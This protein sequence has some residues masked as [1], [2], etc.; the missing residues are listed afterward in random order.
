MPQRLADA[1]PLEPADLS[2]FYHQ[3][4]SQIQ[5]ALQQCSSV[6]K[7]EE[8]F[9]TWATAIENS[10][11]LAIQTEHRADPLQQPTPCLPRACRGRCQYR[12][13]KPRPLSRSAPHGRHGDYQA[14]TEAITVKARAKVRQ[15]RRLTTLAQGLRKLS[16]QTGPGGFDLHGQLRKEW[17]AIKRAQG[18]P[19]QFPEWL[20]RTQHF[21]EDL[22][23]Q[24][25]LN[26]VLQFVR[27]DA[28][29]TVRHEAKYRAKV[30]KFRVHQDQ[31]TGHSRLGFSGLRP[32]ARPPF[33]HVPVQENQSA[34][35]VKAC[36][37][38]VG[39]YRV[40][41]PE[42]VKQD[43]AILIDRQAAELLEHVES[44]IDGHLLRIK[45]QTSPLP[46][47]AT[48]QQY[49]CAST[50]RELHRAFI[51]FWSPIWHR[52]KGP[53]RD[54]EAYWDAFLS[55]LPP[56]P[57]E[58]ATFELDIRDIALWRQQQRCL[59]NGKAT[60]YC[61]FSPE[62]L[63]CLP[64][65]ALQDLA[66]LFALSA[67]YGFPR[68]LAK[69]T[70]HVLAKVDSPQHI[71][72]GRPITVYATIYRF[73][74]SVMAKAILRHWATWLPDSVRGCVPGRG[75]REVSL[76]IQCM[77]EEALLTGQP[78]GGFSID[79]EKC[80]NQLPRLP[81]RCLLR[82][83]GVPE[84][85]L[86]IWFSFLDNNCRHAL[87]QQD[88]SPP[89]MSTTGVPEGDPLS[90][91][92]QIAVCWA[93]VA[94]PLPPQAWPWTFVDNLSW[95][96]RTSDALQYLLKDAVQFCAGLALPI[97]WKKSFCWA[98]TK[99][100][101]S[102][103]S[104]QPV[105]GGSPQQR[106]SLVSDAKDLGVVYRFHRQGGMGKAQARI[107]EGISRLKRLQRQHRSL[108]NAAHLVQTGVWPAALYGLEGHCPR[109]QQLD[110]L[111]TGAA[112]ALVGE[113]HSMSPHLALSCIT[114]R[115]D[116]PGVYLLVQSI[117]ALCR[118][119][120]L[121]P[122]YGHLWL[123]LAQTQQTTAKRAIGPATALVLQLKAQDW[124]LCPNGVLKGPGHWH[125]NLFVDRPKVVH[126]ACQAAWACHLP[127]RVQHRNGL[128]RVGVPCPSL[129]RR[130]LSRFKP[131]DQLQLAHNIV[132]GFMSRAAR[133]QYDPLV[134][135]TCDLCGRPDTKWHRIFECEALGPTRRAFGPLLAWVQANCPHWVHSPFPTRP[136]KEDF[137]R[138]LWHSRPLLE[139]PS[140]A[141]A[142]TA[143]SQTTLQLFTDGSCA[144]PTCPAAR[145]AAW[146]VVLRNPAIDATTLRALMSQ[147]I[148]VGAAYPVLVQG[149]L[150]G[151]Q[152]IFRAETAALV[153]VARLA[154]RHPEYIFQTWTDSSSALQCLTAWLHGREIQTITAPVGDLLQ[155]LP[156]QRPG[157]L[158]LFKVKAHQTFHDLADEDLPVALGNWAADEAA[159]AA[160][161]ADLS[162]VPE[163]VQEVADW[164]QEQESRF[165]MF[166]Q[167]LLELTK[168]V[169]RLRKTAGA[170]AATPRGTTE[171]EAPQ[172]QQWRALQPTLPTC[173]VDLPFHVGPPKRKQI[174]AWPEWFLLSILEWGRELQ[175]PQA[176][177]TDGYHHLSGITFLELMVNYV[178]C[179]KK[180]PP[181]RSTWQ[182]ET[183]YVD[184]LQAAGILQPIVVRESL[185][186]FLAAVACLDKR[187]GMRIW[188][189]ARHHRLHCLE[190][191][192]EVNG[193]KGLID[194]PILPRLDL[195]CRVLGELLQTSCGESLRSFSLK[196]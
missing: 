108:L 93:L 22:P 123:Q 175:W 181:V 192:G 67:E 54:Q 13:I 179:T 168:A 194:R 16:Q 178:V 43:R 190:C 3:C 145:H 115:L 90:V 36:A 191:F 26:D 177:N 100:L 155:H 52:D 7:L 164:Y 162:C 112:R 35:L 106:L 150:P 140:I 53:A 89:V 182:G 156:N 116:D 117:N 143:Q 38:D 74:A 101:R 169:T 185:V 137:L 121:L 18:Y 72:Q 21:W 98:T 133:A 165:Y 4:R 158:Q 99:T 131:G 161:K 173:C 97:D 111:R 129:T 183:C 157:N 71:G 9:A 147:T 1:S 136:E 17:A 63:K 88:L 188:P 48:L 85:V 51:E 159:K 142:L 141:D 55:A 146:S 64:P 172:A 110:Q 8:A 39:L 120:R 96:A 27:F 81:L 166:C 109:Q 127:E 14:P 170:G 49:S 34:Q 10:V 144:F 103:W 69:A 153:Q 186:N 83:L 138:L 41:A 184:P 160:E 30:A 84:N 139:P 29:A 124:T 66:D 75:V 167:Y 113:R 33:L 195:T 46:A 62:E 122:D 125:I 79:I 68:H 50:A 82:H 45:C 12:D 5:A 102:F 189:S 193:R 61:G 128:H 76:V 59:K 152:T 28:D 77:V 174:P 91:V 86:S 180:L 47:K 95:V 196:Q 105:P 126:A 187:L 37:S 11:D 130:V 58:V 114:D 78:L 171:L 176:A 32:H 20:L 19:P 154:N 135:K 70:V 163:Y 132:G 24:D 57:P 31:T 40:P 60:G 44:E 87:F 94:R 151:D 119:L 118:L 25:W 148:A 23:P 107:T 134:E 6:D 73:W 56:P 80:F 104:H 42:F 15:V 149:L 92:A 2:P 65:P